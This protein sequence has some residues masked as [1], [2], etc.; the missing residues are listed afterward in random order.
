MIRTDHL[1]TTEYTQT[2]SY[3]VLDVQNNIETVT[4][5]SSIKKITIMIAI[6]SMD[7]TDKDEDNA[8]YVYLKSQKEYIN[9]KL[10]SLHTT[11]TQAYR[12]NII[13][14]ENCL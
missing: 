11:H 12:K 13:S 9:I 5:T 3:C 2:C 10:Y 1:C 14:C 4:G 6:I 7:L 8:L